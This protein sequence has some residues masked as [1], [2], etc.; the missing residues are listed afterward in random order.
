[1]KNGLKTTKLL[2]GKSHHSVRA[3]AARRFEGEYI[4]P[5]PYMAS[6][7]NRRTAN[8]GRIVAV[9][10]AGDRDIH[11]IGGASVENLRLKPR[12]ATLNPPGISVIKAPTPGAAA[13][14]M[15]TGL[16]KAKNLHQQAKTV[17]SATEEAIRGGLRCYPHTIC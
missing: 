5:N 13:Q 7:V 16:P 10:A 12:E 4:A 6:S 14:E 2:S 1:M 8:E 9:P 15:R 11:R 17:G 3:R